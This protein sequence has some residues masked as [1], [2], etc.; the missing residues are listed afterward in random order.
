MNDDMHSNN[1]IL[2]TI[3]NNN[4]LYQIKETEFDEVLLKFGSLVSMLKN[5]RLNQT[6]F[7]MELLDSEI[8]RECFKTLSGIDELHILFYNLIIRFPVLCKSKIIKTKIKEINDKRR[9]KKI[10]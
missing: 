1:A 7:L 9:R 6:M 8:H 10:V 5:K 4:P 2:Q 3:N